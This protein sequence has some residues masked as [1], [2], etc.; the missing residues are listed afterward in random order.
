MND[1]L[2]SMSSGCSSTTAWRSWYGSFL[3]AEG[4]HVSP[5]IAVLTAGLIIGNTLRSA[6]KSESAA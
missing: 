3:G 2:G 4:L 6:S 1:P 5:V